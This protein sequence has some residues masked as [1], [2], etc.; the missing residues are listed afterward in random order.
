MIA[1]STLL[2]VNALSHLMSDEMWPVRTRAVEI[3]LAEAL[4]DTREVGENNRGER[5][6]VYLQ[7]AG[8]LP[9]REDKPGLGWCGMFIY[10]CYSQAA[11]ELGKTLPSELRMAFLSGYRLGVWAKDNNK[12]VKN[13]HL[14]PGDI[15]TRRVHWHI[16]MV[17]EPVSDPTEHTVIKT[18]D[19]NQSYE[20]SGKDSVKVRTRKFGEMRRVIRL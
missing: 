5:I 19:G 7:N 6:D 10:F 14:M 18:I 16:G 13:G 2:T 17:I 3:A 12:F 4:E 8:Q 9:K 20:G 1:S 15:Y 11:L